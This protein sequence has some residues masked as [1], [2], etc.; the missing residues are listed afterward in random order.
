MFHLLRLP[1]FFTGLLIGAAI[2]IT[3]HSPGSPPPIED[4]DADA[5][6]MESEAPVACVEIYDTCIFG[7]RWSMDT[8]CAFLYGDCLGQSSTVACELGCGYAGAPAACVGPCVAH[9][10]SR[11]Y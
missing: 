9:R 8:E 3:C 2:V 4:G 1:F 11:D 10:F 5:H 6:S 7:A